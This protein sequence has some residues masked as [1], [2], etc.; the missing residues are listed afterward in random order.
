MSLWIKD[1]FRLVTESGVPVAH[2]SKANK[3]TRL[4]ERKVCFILEAG[5]GRGGAGFCPKAGP[6][7]PTDNLWA[8]TFIGES[9][10]M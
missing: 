3:E 2:C 5:S 9:E 7:T 4:V 8:R 6:P 1:N 10:T